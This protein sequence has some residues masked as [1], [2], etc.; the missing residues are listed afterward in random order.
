M[1]SHSTVHTIGAPKSMQ[2]VTIQISPIAEQISFNKK[3]IFKMYEK[4]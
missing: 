3:D 2:N 1:Q 4:I